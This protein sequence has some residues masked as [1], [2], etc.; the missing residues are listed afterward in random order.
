MKDAIEKK[1]ATVRNMKFDKSE[2]HRPTP[3]PSLRCLGPISSK[4][5]SLVQVLL[6]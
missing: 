2:L 6:S 1:Y 3:S 4:N 5:P